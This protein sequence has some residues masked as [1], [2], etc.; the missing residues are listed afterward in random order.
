MSKLIQKQI[1]K[2]IIII[3]LLVVLGGYALSVFCIKMISFRYITEMSDTAADFA[4]IVINADDAKN[5]LNTRKT[6]ND[7]IKTIENIKKY[8]EKNEDIK[9]ISF[10]SFGNTCGYVIYDT[11]EGN[12]LGTKIQYDMYTE[13]YKTDLI[14][15]RNSWIIGEGKNITNFKPLRTSDDKLAGYIIVNVGDAQNNRF[16][17]LIT[18]VFSVLLVVSLVL[19]YFIL[20]YIRREV[21]IPIKELSNSAIEY[22]VAISENNAN[23]TN[24]LFVINKDNEVGELG[25]AMNKVISDINNSTEN[26]SNAIYDATHDVLTKAY[27]KR[28][29]SEMSPKF[30]HYSSICVIFFDVNNLK[31]MNDTLGHERGDYVIRSAAEYIRKFTSDAN[32]CFRIGGDEF[33]LIMPECSFREID[34]LIDILDNDA[35]YILSAEEDTIK[36]ALSYGYSYAKAPYIY[37]DIYIEAEENM[38][39][40]KAELKKLL[41]MPD[42]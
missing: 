41:N 42:R 34:R 39:K 19:V 21:F 1:N 32:M 23:K 4:E 22:T 33:V 14:N 2:K 18:V 11:Q 35:P 5:Y 26:L 40:K 3:M 10:I 29:Y 27:N 25:K 7:Y 38:Y 6:D 8:I 20:R 13:K 37:Q 9:R 17:I 30:Q 36:C 24:E 28:Y 12:T 31:L 16:V 15:G